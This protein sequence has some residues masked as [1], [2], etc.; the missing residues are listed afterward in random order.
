MRYAWR[1]RYGLWANT[2]RSMYT[3]NQHR[4]QLALSVLFLSTTF[5]L[6]P[7]E[8]IRAALPEVKDQ[9]PTVRLQRI[10]DGRRFKKPLALYQAPGNN[11]RWYV[12][13][14]AGRIVML[15]R[16]GSRKG[17][18]FA[19]LTDRVEDGP[20]EAGLL[21]MAF[22]PKFADNRRVY[23]SYTRRGSPLVSY[24]SQFVASA[25]ARSLET[26]SEQPVLTV[27]QPWGNHNGG[28]I[29]FGPDGYLYIGLGDGGAGGDPRE[30]GQN[31]GT[32]LGAMLRIDI[33]G[34]PPYAIPADNPFAAG[35]AGRPE[36]YAWGLRNPWRWSF[37]RNTGRLWVADVGQDR[38]EEINQ[39]RAGAN[40]G[41]NIREGAHCFHNRR[42][43]GDGLVDPVAEYGHNMGCSVT[44][45]Y[46]YRGTA[47]P[48]LRGYYV[49]ADYC[50][51]RIWGL[52]VD[53][54][55]PGNPVQL[56]ASDLRVSSFAEGHDGELY[57]VDH[58]GEIFRAAPP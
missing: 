52:R 22:H 15:E 21:G 29:A 27:E 49:Y 28:Q 11:S 4:G 32:L 46:V 34:P 18:I 43:R 39:V 7:T 26:A 20:N 6:A 44:G 36:I 25:D 35:G 57:V 55:P 2:S 42:C 12:L 1:N 14:Q 23:I 50:S 24:V 53:A 19:D 40:Y 41:W 54:T 47:L 51:G 10:F 13:E 45:G 16:E 38:W 37:D 56:L 30:H 33:D 58:G 48:A 31:P 17:R 5:V 9:P 3:T 8:A